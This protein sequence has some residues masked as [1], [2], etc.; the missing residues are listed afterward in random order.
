M[1]LVHCFRLVLMPTVPFWF[2]GNQ[3]IVR[4]IKLWRDN[5]QFP[6]ARPEFSRQYR[7]NMLLQQDLRQVVA[8]HG[9]SSPLSW[10]PSFRK[11]HLWRCFSRPAAFPLGPFSS[12]ATVCI[13]F[14][15]KNSRSMQP[16]FQN[17]E[18]LS[19]G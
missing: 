11:G 16:F 15:G 6:P 4:I 2:G 8:E 17:S 18:Y 14:I 7:Y 1:Y 3:T 19:I 13:P 12:A 5:G 10:R 9:R